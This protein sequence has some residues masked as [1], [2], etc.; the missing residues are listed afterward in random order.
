MDNKRIGLFITSLRKNKNMTQKG[1]A[2]KLFISD[3]AVSKWERGLAMP[4][5]GLIERVAEVLDVSV[6]EILKGEKLEEMTKKSSDE[7]VKESI[8]FFQKDYFKRKIIRIASCIIAFL[9]LG[10]FAILCLGEISYGTFTWRIFDGEYSIDLPSFSSMKARSASEKFLEALKDYNDEAIQMILRENPSKVTFYV[11]NPSIQ[12]GSGELKREEEHVGWANYIDNLE[13]VE[14]EG[15][16]FTG[17][18]YNS[19]YHNQYTYVCQFDVELEY[20]KEK[21]SIQVQLEHYDEHIMVNSYGYISNDSLNVNNSYIFIKTNNSDLYR[22]IEKVF[23][24]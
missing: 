13:A 19:M 3:K 4:D 1:L 7:I 18:K 11:A 5:I 8:P 21:Y 10:Y 2:T 16:K 22:Q 17:Y 12:F 9:F 23:E 15:V 20:N 14:K 24:F 6:S